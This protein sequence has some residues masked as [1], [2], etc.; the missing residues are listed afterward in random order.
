MTLV[1]N[2]NE[3]VEGDIDQATNQGTDQDVGQVSEI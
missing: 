3:S 1:P 2:S